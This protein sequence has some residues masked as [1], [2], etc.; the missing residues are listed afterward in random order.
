MR[1][2]HPP[3]RDGSDR[4]FWREMVR[5]KSF[6]SGAGLC[7]SDS[8]GSRR[9]LLAEGGSI[10]SMERAP[11]DYALVLR[12]Q[13]GQLVIARFRRLRHIAARLADRLQQTRIAAQCRE[14]IAGLERAA[15]I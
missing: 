6:I 12:P 5:P 15:R 4:A 9:H 11:A 8:R 3:R 1:L 7:I 2:R 14:D 10:P 13:P